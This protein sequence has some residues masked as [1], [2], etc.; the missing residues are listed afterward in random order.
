[1]DVVLQRMWVSMLK[2]SRRCVSCILE[3]F[4]ERGYRSSFPNR[5]QTVLQ[6]LFLLRLDI[7]LFAAASEVA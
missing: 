3:R 5:L 4:L 2:L 6:Q 7:K 1:M